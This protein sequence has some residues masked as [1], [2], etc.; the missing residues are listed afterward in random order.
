MAYRDPTFNA[1][2]FTDL[3][4]TYLENQSSEREKY[5]KAE[6]QMSKPIF[7]ASGKNIVRI[8][9][10]TG[11]SAIVY[12]GP[13]EIKEPKF[14]EFPQVDKDNNPTG[15]TIKGQFTGTKKPFAGVPL[16]YEPVGKKAQ[17]KPE[18]PKKREREIENKDIERMISDRKTLIRRKNKNYDMFDIGLIKAGIM[19]IDFSNKGQER[20][21]AIEK[22]LI[23]KGFDIY[24]P[25]TTQDLTI[26]KTGSE[27]L[28]DLDNTLSYVNLQESSD[29]PSEKDA[30]YFFSKKGQSD[31]KK[32]VQEYE[33]KY[34]PGT[35]DPLKTDLEKMRFWDSLTQKYLPKNLDS[36]LGNKLLM[37]YNY[38]TANKFNKP[39]EDKT[40]SKKIN[41]WERN[42]QE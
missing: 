33:E 8:D 6:Q 27:L 42:V 35:Y 38:D 31:F 41:F 23:E 13:K 1:N 12:E 14:E 24:N 17:F 9:P 20:L 28:Q 22:K 5:Y 32:I 36:K 4:S 11:Q 18:D 34:K 16:G 39:E 19:P 3:L 37:Q 10:R 26:K 2:L 40:P 15:M 21:D 29:P 30:K 7:R 25:E